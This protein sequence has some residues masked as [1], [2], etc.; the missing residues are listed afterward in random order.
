LPS[1]NIADGGETK[2]GEVTIGTSLLLSPVLLKLPSRGIADGGEIKLGEVSQQKS[3]VDELTNDD[4]AGKRGP[5][6][7]EGKTK[8]DELANA[9]KRGSKSVAGNSS[10]VDE[11]SNGTEAGRPKRRS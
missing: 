6:P 11:P 5:N 2:L 7:V 1:R 10:K 9:G 8:V 3:K 4:E